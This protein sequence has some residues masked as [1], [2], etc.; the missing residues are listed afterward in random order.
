[1]AGNEF[2]PEIYF[3]A[4]QEYMSELQALY[5]ARQYRMLMYAA[6]VAVECMLRAYRCRIDPEFD[7]RHDLY[8]LSKDARFAALFPSAAIEK[9]SA[10]LADV[11]TRWSN[12]HRYRSDAAMRAFL[13]RAKLDR[14]IK[15][16]SLKENARRISN[17]ATANLAWSIRMEE[18]IRRLYELLHAQFANSELTLEQVPGLQRVGGLLA[19]EGFEGLE[20]MDRQRHLWQ[21][22]R[23]SLPPEDQLRITA[24]LTM[25]PAELAVT[26]E[27]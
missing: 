19:W 18:L 7:A 2:K 1:M 12:N 21:V 23:A 3:H 14:G 6:G 27:G 15:G 20:Q 10:A 22:L 16:D 24:I 8:Q 17:A 9:Y 26:R 11:T 13:K 25:T 4:A 5:D